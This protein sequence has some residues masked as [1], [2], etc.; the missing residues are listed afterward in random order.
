MTQKATKRLLDSVW[1][2][3]YI[4]NDDNTITIVKHDR[5]DS[6]GYEKEKEL[7]RFKIVENEK[8]EAL[9]VIIQDYESPF[10]HLPNENNPHY[11]YEVAN[12]RHVFS[13]SLM[14]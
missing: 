6:E 14:K 2:L 5:G 13:Y 7:P 3:E 8:R 12:K 4:I 1:T 11:A 10:T 9:R